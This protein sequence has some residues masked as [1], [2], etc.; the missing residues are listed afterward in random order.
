MGRPKRADEAGG[1]YHALHRGNAKADIFHKS[2]D[3]DAIERILAE[4]LELYPCQI[5][6]HQLMSNHWHL[7]SRPP[8]TAE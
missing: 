5:L 7:S 2:E 3:F 1:I 6:S 8:K 4:G